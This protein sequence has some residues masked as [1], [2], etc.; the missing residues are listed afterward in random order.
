MSLK[1]SGDHELLDERKK[2]HFSDWRGLV[3]I[4]FENDSTLDAPNCEYF[5]HYYIFILST[6]DTR[7]TLED[8]SNGFDKQRR[9]ICTDIVNVISAQR[10]QFSHAAHSEI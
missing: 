7:K 6:S 9:R 2:N 3:Q 10:S 8:V 1:S 4:I 5:C